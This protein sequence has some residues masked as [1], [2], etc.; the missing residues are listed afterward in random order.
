MCVLEAEG[1]AEGERASGPPT[2]GIGG[3]DVS[4][5]PEFL[6]HQQ[7]GAPRWD[8]HP[9]GYRQC[10][11]CLIS[12]VSL[13]ETCKAFGKL[14]ESVLIGFGGVQWRATTWTGASTARRGE[15]G[16]RPAFAKSRR[17]DIVKRAPQP[18]S[19]DVSMLEVK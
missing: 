4:T 14:P 5:P 3:Q 13:F 8:S 1:V 15:A 16:T 10:V 18:E 6:R 7:D 11:H 17:M 9:A 2:P 19:L 12:S